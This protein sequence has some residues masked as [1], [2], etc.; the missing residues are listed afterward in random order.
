MKK[1]LFL[2]IDLVLLFT[3]CSVLDHVDVQGEE[4]KESLTHQGGEV[5]Y[6]AN[7]SS[8]SYHLKSCHIAKRISDKNR[9]ETTDLDFLLGR[10]FVPCKTCLAQENEANQP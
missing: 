4:T 10:E 2:I 1:L 7:T 3:S 9:W 5:T 6:V 8:K